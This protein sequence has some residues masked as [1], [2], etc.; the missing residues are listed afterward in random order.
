MYYTA[1]LTRSQQSFNRIING[2][3]APMRKLGV[4]P[5]CHSERLPGWRIHVKHSAPK[6]ERKCLSISSGR[7]RLQ[8]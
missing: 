5:A 2:R 3:L 7:N 6:N 1:L 4:A 8:L